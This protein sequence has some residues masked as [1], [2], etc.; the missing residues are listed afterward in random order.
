MAADIG[1][2][3]IYLGPENVNISEY[4]ILFDP[5]KELAQ[6]PPTYPLIT[7]KSIGLNLKAHFRRPSPKAL[8]GVVSLLREEELELLDVHQNQS[9]PVFPS[10][11]YIAM[12]LEAAAMIVNCQLFRPLEINTGDSCHNHS[13]LLSA[14]AVR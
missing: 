2:F 8:L 1:S 7:R 6:E 5:S 14:R 9:Q 10:T 4:V 12:A 13:R 11:G 3:W